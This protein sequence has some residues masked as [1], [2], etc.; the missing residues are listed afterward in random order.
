MSERIGPFATAEEAMAAAEEHYRQ[1]L[2][3]N[4]E[5]ADG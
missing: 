5:E 2:L 4:P 3:E 1:W